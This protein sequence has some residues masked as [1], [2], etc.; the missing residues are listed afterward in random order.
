MK[1]IFA[2]FM[3]LC[4]VICTAQRGPDHIDMS[5]EQIAE[6]RTKKLALALD[7][8]EKQREQIREIELS[9]AFERE[10]RKE[11]RRE[12]NSKP[13]ADQRYEM[14]NERLDK[15]L[16]LKE[17]MKGILN[18]E[19]FEKWERLHARKGQRGRCKVHRSK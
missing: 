3:M 8:S 15:Q 2:T 17:Q 10:S 5:P 18:K 14:I 6:L 12:R 11:V 19:Q 4:G 7:L 1:I 13:D 16:A 9:E